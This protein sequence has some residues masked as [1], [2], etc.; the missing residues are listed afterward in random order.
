MMIKMRPVTVHQVPEQVTASEERSFLRELHKYVE[1]ERPRLVLD[2][3][4]VRQMD[5]TTI[6]LLLSCLEEAMKRKG[7]VK[8]ASLAP[9]A[10]ATLRLTGVNRLF[11]FYATTAGAVH[12]FQHRSSSLIGPEFETA[13]IDGESESAA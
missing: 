11:E 1:T 8:L 5:N 10:E 2:C 13:D 7:D 12:S 9:E 4:R 3:S 6:H